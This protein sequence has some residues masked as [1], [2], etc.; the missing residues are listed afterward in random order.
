ME[1]ACEGYRM[2]G[3]TRYPRAQLDGGWRSA[4]TATATVCTTS[5][6]SSVRATV[7]APLSP[8]NGDEEAP[9]RA[10]Q[11]ELIRLVG[12]SGCIL[13]IHTA[14]EEYTCILSPFSAQWPEEPARRLPPA[15]T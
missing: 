10:R 7:L 6:P 2:A 8:R 14:R 4:R 11:E 12:L 9:L 5:T 1:A 13:E 3:E 15:L